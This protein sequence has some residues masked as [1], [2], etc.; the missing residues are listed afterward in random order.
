MYAYELGG[1]IYCANCYTK[2]V[3]EADRKPIH[4]VEGTEFYHRFQDK[5]VECVKCGISIRYDQLHKATYQ[6]FG[7]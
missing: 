3:A 1:R 2:L 4:I 5:P 6:S 7:K